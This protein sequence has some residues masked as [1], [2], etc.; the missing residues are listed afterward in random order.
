M[1]N[2]THKLKLLFAA[3]GFAML[4]IGN[5]V[6][7]TTAIADKADYL[8]PKKIRV[9]KNN[10]I[11][12][13]RIKLG[14]ILFFD[15]RLS[16]SNQM[17]CATCHNP[18]FAW[19][20]GLAL[21]VGRNNKTMTRATPTILNV[22]YNRKFFWDGRARSLEEQAVGPIESA[23]EM[24]QKIEDLIAELKTIKGYSE[25]FEKAYPGEG[26]SETT[27]GKALATFERTI[28]SN[29]DAPFDRWIAGDA[30]AI[31]ASAKRGF[32][33]FDGKAR[34]SVCHSGATF[35]DGSF[36]NIGLSNGNDVGRY[37]FVKVKALK[38][39]FKTPTL[40]NVVR[41]APYM[42]NGELKTMEDVIDHYI[43]G[44]KG[45]PNLSPDMKPVKLSKQEK[46]DLIEFLNTLTEEEPPVTFPILPN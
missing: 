43:D 31:S 18:S 9:P 5:P 7:V 19:T 17:S 46:A 22:A 38:G 2:L 29:F 26:I 3:A 13:E 32:E 8:P 42:H 23:I 36:H 12:P 34:C 6:L 30:K 28:V 1:N 11:T 10:Q 33:L 41:T 21:S 16:D 24:N 15:P 45:K 27:I 40:R 20:D 4:L 14:K 37:E 39:A 35:T 25:L 44:A